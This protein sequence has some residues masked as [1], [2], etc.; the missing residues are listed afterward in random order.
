MAN[1]C[2]FAIEANMLGSDRLDA[3]GSAGFFAVNVTTCIIIGRSHKSHKTCD[4]ARNSVVSTFTIS[5]GI[6]VVISR[7]SYSP[8]HGFGRSRT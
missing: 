3:K 1:L 6:R 2:I 8:T 7:D 4:Q 5:P